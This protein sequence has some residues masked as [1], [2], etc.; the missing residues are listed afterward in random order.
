MA[1]VPARGLPDSEE[2]L[3]R[4]AAH[5]HEPA[6]ARIVR[7]RYADLVRVCLVITG[8]IALARVAV[9]ETWPV[10]MRELGELRD[11]SRLRP[12]LCAIGADEA[13]PLR[14]SP[15]LSAAR[16]I[17]R[18]D[19]DLPQ[20][21]GYGSSDPALADAL[22]ALTPDDRAVLALFVIGGL[23]DTELARAARTSP[24]LARE[25][26]HRLLARLDEVP[27]PTGR[28]TANEPG[29]GERRLRALAEVPVR[30]LDAD[31]VAHVA[32]AGLVVQRHHMVSVGVSLVIATLIF[33]TVYALTAEYAVPPPLPGASPTP[34]LPAAIVIDRHF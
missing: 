27:D 21:V 20:G 15:A 1:N 25:R 10:A 30:P 23:D 12:W 28:T 14:P 31:A 24:D 29:A 17:R 34:H 22:S 18:T 16:E 4:L 8:D 2:E 3:V 6:F 13:R 5:G 33:A 26:L 11:P 19:A 32:R 9:A 7:L